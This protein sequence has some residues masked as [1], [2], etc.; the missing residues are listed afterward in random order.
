[1]FKGNEEIKRAAIEIGKAI[2]IVILFCMA[3][4]LLFAFIVKVAALPSEVIAPVNRVIKA[5]A[6]F[7]GCIIAVRESGGWIKGVIIGVLSV[8]LS[9]VLFSLIGGSFTMEWTFILEL[10]FGGII[11]AISGIIAINIHK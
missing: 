10:L 11:G 7:L 2:G 3:A 6:V 8:L 4:V 5:V 1:M 9:Y